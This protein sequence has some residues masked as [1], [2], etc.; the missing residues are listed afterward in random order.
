MNNIV[1][2]GGYFQV[3]NV[4]M[5]AG[6]ISNFQPKTPF[7]AVEYNDI[8]NK[9]DKSD[10]QVVSALPASPVSGVYYFVKE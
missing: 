6:V 5:N 1:G 3:G 7:H 2:T 9:L 4:D 8:A 10:M